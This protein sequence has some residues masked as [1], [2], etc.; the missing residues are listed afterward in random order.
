[1][2]AGAQSCLPLLAAEPL[3]AASRGAFAPTRATSPR[4][5]RARNLCPTASGRSSRQ[6]RVRPI[7]TPGSRPCG[8]GTASG[9]RK[10]PNR[11]PINELGFRVLHHGAG[12][13]NG[14]SGPNLYTFVRNE[15]VFAMDPFGLSLWV[16]TSRAFGIIGISHVYMW[17]DR[18]ETPKG[19]HDCSMQGSS[20]NP[21][22]HDD[23]LKGPL[24]GSGEGFDLWYGDI[25][26]GV[27]CQRIPNSNGKEDAAIKC[28]RDKAN[29]RIWFPGLNDCH[30]PLDKCLTAPPP[31]G[32]GIPAS[33]IPPHK[34]FGKNRGVD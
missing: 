17:D 20:G 3:S 16:C 15:P 25:D 11:D 21:N 2:I 30:N 32:A 23:S 1:V 34:R 7:I 24:P 33:D 14:S 27:S 31:A 19:K 22:T 6:R 5:T 10:W 18:K 4:K 8:Y 12:S 29:K 26:S 9:R 13:V 28:C